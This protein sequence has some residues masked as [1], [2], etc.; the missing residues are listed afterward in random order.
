MSAAALANHMR[1]IAKQAV[2]SI[3]V[4][5]PGII[6]SVNPANGAVKVTLQP[7]GI[8]T[9]FIPYMSALTGA[10]GIVALPLQ[11]AQVLVV[12]DHGDNEAGVAVGS[13]WDVNNKPPAN[14]A[15]GEV[16]LTNVSGSVVKITNDGK[17]TATDKSGSIVVLSGDGKVTITA[18][19]GLT[20]NANVTVNG[21]VTATG[22]GTFSGHTVTQ[23]THGGVTA[24][25]A[26]TA[27]PT[28]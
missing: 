11:G 7:G 10:S 14:Y 15:P 27:T 12:F 21:K 13:L 5:M 4:A 6:K 20:I 24:G 16:W 18:S 22:E 9:G 8:E 3:S 19:G 1:Q 23:H 26:F 25:G 17:I 28:G 2:A